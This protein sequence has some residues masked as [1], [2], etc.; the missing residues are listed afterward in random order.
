[1]YCFSK[2]TPGFICLLSILFVPFLGI[3]QTIIT[4][5]ISV[6]TTWELSG[7]PYIL[8]K[9]ITIDENVSLTIKPDVII[10]HDDF[11]W[12]DALIVEGTLIAQGTASQ[13]MILVT[14]K[15]AS[16]MT[17]TNKAAFKTREGGLLSIFS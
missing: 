1:M 3:S 10:K 7:S 13:P 17:H 15:N 2:L 6:N 8:D 9:T 11:N 14:G 4:D 12:K 5:D 16:I